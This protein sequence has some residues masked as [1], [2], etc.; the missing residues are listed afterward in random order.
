[1]RTEVSKFPAASSVVL[2][3]SLV[4]ASLI[5]ASGSALAGCGGVSS[6]QHTGAHG[7]S[8]AT[9]VHTGATAP[10]HSTGTPALSSC[11][12]TANNVIAAP[13]AVVATGPIGGQHTF[14]HNSTTTHNNDVA[15]NQHTNGVQTHAST[16]AK[17]L[18][19]PKP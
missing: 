13:H 4:T 16:S 5:G 11:P 8:A 10:S 19:A 12:S 9:G 1:M 6:Y 2:L 18:K 17:T 3:A 15:N 14:T 7:A